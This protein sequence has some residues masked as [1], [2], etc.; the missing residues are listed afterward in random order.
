MDN[1]SSYT[2]LIDE[3]NV[4]DLSEIEV[5]PAAPRKKRTS[6]VPTDYDPTPKFRQTEKGFQRPASKC[7]VSQHIARPVRL[8]ELHH[9]WRTDLVSMSVGD[10]KNRFLSSL[11][12]SV[13]GEFYVRDKHTGL[14]Q[15]RKKQADVKSVIMNDWGREQTEYNIRK[16]T[17]DEFFA[18][19]EYVVLDGL[20][21]VPG[22]GDFVEVKGRRLLN[23]HH[24]PQLAYRNN[25]YEAEAFIALMELIVHNLLGIDEGDIDG[26]IDEIHGPEDTAIKWVFHWLAS[27]YQR[28]GKALPTALWFVGRNQ[29]VGK[30]LFAS[31]MATLL[32]HAN[33]KNVSAEEFKGD[34]TDFM[35]GGAFF[36]LDEVDFGS[37]KE[38]YDK[39][40]RLIGNDFIAVRKRHQGDF[41][42][43]AI[44]NFLFT[45]NNTS[46]LAIDQGDRRH[47]FFETSNST[48]ARG[49]ASTFYDLGPEAHKSAW[50]G[51]AEFLGQIEIDTTLISKAFNTDVKDRMVAGNIEPVEEWLQTDRMLEE[52]PVGHFAPT[53]WLS[54]QYLEWAQEH[55]FPGCR[56]T[57]Y[58][59]RMLGELGSMG[60]VSN[61]V[62][63]HQSR[64]PKLRGYVR[65][66][67]ENFEAY[68]KIGDVPFIPKYSVSSNVQNIREK[69]RLSNRS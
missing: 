36:I 39:T 54:R 28:P 60:L 58:F 7:W 49:R 41:E 31:G 63:K 33:V 30:G 66:E 45:T 15:L 67:P 57:K 61:P 3:E 59:H 24:E 27:Q 4:I 11:I 8:A 50:E 44:A 20:V 34:W 56:T 32:G 62:R 51:M 42:I 53:D 48:A 16:G 17:L 21:F 14:W 2:D 43:P 26:W 68:D 6:R 37:R 1:S 55:A 35:V 10:R 64:G 25:A 69:R 5:E 13:A 19:Q 22:G 46:P 47:T 23:T 18:G 12:V 29:G 9:L 52:W 40:K 38:F 65:L